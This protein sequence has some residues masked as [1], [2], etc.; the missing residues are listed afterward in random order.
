MGGN[1]ADITKPDADRAWTERETSQATAYDDIGDRYDDAFPHKEGQVECVDLL[2]GKLPPGARVL[3]VGCGTGLPTSR[4]LADAGCEVTGID[5]SPGMLDIARRNV[6]KARFLRFDMID[7]AAE[8]DRYD[9]VVAFFSLLHLPRARIPDALESIH[10]VLVPGGR[11]CLAMV[12]ADV[13]DL[14]IPFLGHQVRVTGYFRDEL[15]SV[16]GAAGFAIED[17]TARSYAPS[18][19]QAQAEVQLFLTCR[20]VG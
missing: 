11:F 3:D 18:S 17:E 19:T 7:L 6:P 20:R 9:A 16:L 4:Q 8:R 10:R 2:L 1:E 15:R 14:L 13:D 5:I 12:E